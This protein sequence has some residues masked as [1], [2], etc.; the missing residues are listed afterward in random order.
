MR[1]LLSLGKREDR[2]LAILMAA[3]ALVFV[4]Q[5][6]ALSRQAYLEQVEL[7][8]LLAGALFG[9]IFIA[10]LLLYG[11]AA[12][13]HLIAKVFGGQGDWYGAR[14]ALFWSLLAATP[15][16]LL[17]GLVAGFIGPGAGLNLVGLLWCAVFLWFWASSLLA[18]ERPQGAVGA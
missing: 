7:N 3:C 4:S 15:L 1:R 6:P 17:N 18:A 12:L 8:S 14:L 13:S 5:W 10:P 16:M 11:L 9:W 2:A